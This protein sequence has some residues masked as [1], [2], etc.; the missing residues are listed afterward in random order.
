MQVVADGTRPAQV[1]EWPS[2]VRRNGRTTEPM[3]QMTR[4]SEPQPDDP[5]GSGP[6]TEHRRLLPIETDGAPS[7]ELL[8]MILAVMPDAAVVVDGQG[9]VVA[10]NAQVGSLFGFAAHDLVGRPVEVLVPERHRA[11]HR[12]HRQAYTADPAMRSMGTELQLSGRRHDGS[13]FPI[14]VSLAPIGARGRVLVVAAIRDVS[15]RQAAAA[16]QIRLGALVRS[17]H[18]GI[19]T[20]SPQC[21][22][23]SWNPGA[24]RL[25]G[26]E[27]GAMVGAHVSTLVPDDE[28]EAFEDLLAAA[29]DG[30]PAPAADTRWRRVDGTL[31]D[32][33]VSL[34][35]LDPVG[36]D[37]G[38]FSLI[39]RD[40]T[41]RKQAERLAARRE[42]WI[43]VLSDVR[44][45][46]MSEASLA[47]LLERVADLVGD[48]LPG[49]T[50]VSAVD[51][52]G[53]WPEP[54]DAGG[55]LVPVP[56][57]SLAVLVGDERQRV[58]ALDD[59]LAELG[60]V[61]LDLGRALATAGAAHPSEVVS[62]PL[63]GIDAPVGALVVAVPGGVDDDDA[64]G[65]VRVA[66]QVSLGVRLAQ[67]R[68]REE[69]L[70]LADDRARIARDLHDHVIQALFAAGM[71]LQSA[72]PLVVDERAAGWIGDVVGELDETIARIR[73]T[74]FSLQA[75]RDRPAGS[76]R[77]AVLDLC[78]AGANQLGFEPDV[79]FS[80]P[81]E[82][83]S[84]TVRPHLLAVAREALSNAARHAAARQV[85]VQVSVGADAVALV[86]TDD[87][88]GI[89]ESTRRSGLANMRSRA[90]QLGGAL[91][92]STPPGGGTTL[93]WEVPLG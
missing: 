74:I 2:S 68:Q 61:G 54:L 32:V 45:A 15:E 34:S 31:L 16:T 44:L 69:Q 18:D 26:A 7:N 38:G 10:A 78:R 93:V 87:G 19:M 67:A 17:N 51:E 46:I 85:T 5:T 27:A 12:G 82:T 50:V 66:D 25:F 33:A 24:A 20:L 70:L 60:G 39:V 14:D 11:R 47:R 29:T 65:I 58:G 49:A 57:A 88:K 89:G 23:T 84:E 62:A 92:L 83:V 21:T 8:D 79:L 81:V 71:R 36:D 59:L 76:L 80:G 4:P 91:T 40:V 35:S 55:P 52:S 3:T 9:V 53:A 43:E 41:E 42:Q 63:A 64:S 37:P 86:V 1:C 73:S 6:P 77:A 90:E 72:V 30:H 22:I 75:P 13:E 48:V 28:S 56:A